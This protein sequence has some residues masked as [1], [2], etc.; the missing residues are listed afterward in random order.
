MQ[1]KREERVSSCKQRRPIRVNTRPAPLC[2]ALHRN[3]LACSA[4]NP[5]PHSC[6]EKWLVFQASSYCR[7]FSNAATAGE[8]NHFG[9][10][11]YFRENSARI[12][13]SQNKKIIL[14]RS[15][16][17]SSIPEQT[18][19]ILQLWPLW[20]KTRSFKQW[21]KLFWLN[22]N[23]E[24]AAF[25]WLPYKPLGTVAGQLWAALICSELLGDKNAYRFGLEQL[26]LQE[27]NSA[28]WT[29]VED[30]RPIPFI[31]VKAAKR[32]ARG[33]LFFKP[34]KGKCQNSHV[35]YKCFLEAKTENM[36]TFIQP[37]KEAK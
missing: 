17:E 24:F 27:Q 25:R 4:A 15:L 31:T 18:Y 13:F 1:K 35:R 16:P 5:S 28:Y 7:R 2:F 14:D 34:K 3:Q 22:F 33:W 19:Q 10:A 26:G 20:L 29:N 6:C 21:Q 12:V 30:W 36:S 9:L 11:R 8:P 23:G 37:T 32:N